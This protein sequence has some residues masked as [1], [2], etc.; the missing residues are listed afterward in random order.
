M[1]GDPFVEAAIGEDPEGG[2]EVL[3]PVQALVFEVL[4]FRVRPDVQLL[5]ALC[6]ADDLDLSWVVIPLRSVYHVLAW[7]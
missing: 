3:F 5:A 2:G 7:C 4:E 6:L 1:A